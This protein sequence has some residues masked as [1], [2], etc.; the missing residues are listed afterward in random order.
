MVI[1]NLLT[2]CVV[3]FWLVAITIDHVDNLNVRNFDLP[4]NSLSRMIVDNMGIGIVTKSTPLL[5]L[6]PTGFNQWINDNVR[7]VSH[8]QLLSSPMVH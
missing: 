4:T 8:C 5:T 6:Q 1:I 2:F 7:S 3:C